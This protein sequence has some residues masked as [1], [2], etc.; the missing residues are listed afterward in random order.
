MTRRQEKSEV[1]MIWET[2]PDGPVRTNKYAPQ[3]AELKKNPGRWAR[4]RLAESQSGAY[5]SRTAMRRVVDG[6]DRYEFVVRFD[7]SSNGFGI[8]ARYR[9]PEQMDE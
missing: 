4:M 8:W 5:G 6:D 7:D 1:E 3:L 9:T 2:P